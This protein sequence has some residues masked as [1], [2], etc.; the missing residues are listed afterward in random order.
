[1]FFLHIVVNITIMG[2]N[3]NFTQCKL[4]K[5]FVEDD[6][7]LKN[8]IEYCILLGSNIDTS[9]HCDEFITLNDETHTLKKDF[10]PEPVL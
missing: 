8:S 7:S 10:D 9:G 2:K 1:M 6:E 5:Y 4:C 3:G